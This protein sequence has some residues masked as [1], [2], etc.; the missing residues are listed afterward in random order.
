[1]NSPRVDAPLVLGT[2]VP[3]HGELRGSPCPGPAPSGVRAQVQ[4]IV[5]WIDSVVGIVRVFLSIT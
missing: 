2:E 4:R 3:L 5:R 1:M